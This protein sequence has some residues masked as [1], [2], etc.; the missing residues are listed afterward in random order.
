MLLRNNDDGRCSIPRCD[1]STQQT[2]IAS[3]RHAGPPSPTR[4]SELMFSIF[5]VSIALRK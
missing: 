4:H 2:R 5:D 3:G 1:R